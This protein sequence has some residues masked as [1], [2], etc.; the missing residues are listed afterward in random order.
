M[1]KQKNCFIELKK[2]QFEKQ[3]LTEIKRNIKRSF[4]QRRENEK[5]VILYEGFLYDFDILDKKYYVKAVYGEDAETKF[6]DETE[7][8][9]AYVT[10]KI[11]IANK[12]SY[13][14]RINSIKE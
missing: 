5:Q 3:A 9:T 6:D 4:T 14:T 7:D 2:H 13:L 10:Y 12:G 8:L 11:G 1:E